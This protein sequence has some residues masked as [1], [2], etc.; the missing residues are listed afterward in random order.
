MTDHDRYQPAVEWI[1][2][3]LTRCHEEGLGPGLS[4]A[5]TTKDE[6]LATRT[7]GVANADSREPVTDET[8]F[9]I[10]SITKHFTAIACMRLSEQG[11]LDLK[12][13]VTEYL[14]WFEVQLRDERRLRQ[15]RDD[16]D[17][18]IKVPAD[19]PSRGDWRRRN[20]LPLR[21]GVRAD[22]E[23]SCRDGWVL[24]RNEPGLRGSD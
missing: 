9:Q 4:L 24:R 1:D 16:G 8:L 5:L 20:T 19:A 22:D 21:E 13:P 17:G 7:Y 11:R 10:G 23:A 18:A 6:L 12:A 14:D 15:R 2:Q 3:L